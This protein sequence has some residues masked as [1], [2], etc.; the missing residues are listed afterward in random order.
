MESEAAGAAQVGLSDIARLAGVGPAAVSNWR[1]RH[2]SFPRPVGGTERSPRFRLADVQEWLRSQDKPLDLGAPERAWRAMDAVRGRTSIPDMLAS[3]GLVLL[4]RCGEA[5]LAAP[6]GERSPFAA[7]RPLPVRAVAPVVSEMRLGGAEEGS[8]GVFEEL[9]RRFLGAR[10][11][12]GVSATPPELADVMIDLAGPRR[13]PVL[14][15]ACGA[16]GLLAV[17]GARGFSGLLGQ[18]L[19]PALARLAAVRLA[20]LGSPALVTATDTLLDPGWM[21]TAA[22]VVLCHPPFAERSWGHESLVGDPRFGYGLPP[23]GEP[24]LAWLQVALSAVE[25]GGR[26]VIV[27]PP[28]AA[29]RPSGRRLRQA[30]VADGALAAVLALPPGLAAHYA[31]ALQLWVLQRP[32]S[33][34]THRAGIVMAD[35]GQVGDGWPAVRRLAASLVSLLQPGTGHEVVGPPGGTVVRIVADEDVAAVQDVDLTPRR[36]LAAPSSDAPSIR[37]LGHR[38][39]E[40]AQRST[41]LAEQLGALR[42]AAEGLARG[43]PRRGDVHEV[44]LGDLVASGVLSLRHRVPPE[45]GP[46]PWKT[47]AILTVADLAHR[48]PPSGQ[49]EVE[50][51]EL[52]NPPIRSGDVVV[53][54]VSA[55]RRARV[56]GPDDA[57]SY[58]GPGVVVL[59]PDRDVIDPWYL[60]GCLSSARPGRRAARVGSG[61][62]AS[63]KADLRR[64]RIPLPGLDVQKRWGEA[65][66]RVEAAGALARA[67]TTT[68]DDLLDDAGDA[69]AEWVAAGR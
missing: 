54:T 69:F 64:M 1:R 14:D 13:G 38:C 62:G 24:E 68:A 17:A 43:A 41:S 18:E 28:A 52:R 16:G 21:P 63:M 46:V 45:T 4:D 31:L 58:P 2:A 12:S 26:V 15:L 36:H 55:G 32:S 3:I 25:P 65:F 27:M 33:G 40:L 7:W 56:A 47:A 10:S 22:S 9:C 48:Q 35:A 29:A 19:D 66:R 5:T 57:G 42:A 6:R 44:A 51:D 34:G 61:T 30:I 39:D 59:R 20:L 37:E 50:A 8:A 60:A 11:R 53:P 49:G 23:K 67:V